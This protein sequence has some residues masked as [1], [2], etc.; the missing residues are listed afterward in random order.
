M[1]GLQWIEYGVG[2]HEK[3]TRTDAKINKNYEAENINMSVGYSVVDLANSFIAEA[4]VFPQ[5]CD[6]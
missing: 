6:A 5:S 2:L 3:Y 4:Y 1:L